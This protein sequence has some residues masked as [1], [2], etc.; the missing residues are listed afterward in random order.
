MT[1][2]VATSGKIDVNPRSFRLKPQLVPTPGPADARVW[3]MFGFFL[4]ADTAKSFRSHAL[5]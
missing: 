3:K 4:D 2:L 1:Y 5:D